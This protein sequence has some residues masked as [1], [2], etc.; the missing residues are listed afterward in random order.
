MLKVELHT[1]TEDDP[2]DKVPHSTRDLID[3]AISLGYD[4]LAITLHNRQ[5]DLQPWI[6]YAAARG[7]VLIPGVEATVAG[8]HVLLLNFERDAED[9]R[10]FEQLALLKQ[11]S[12]GLVIAPHPYF[13]APTSL[14]GYL[15][16]HAHLFDAVERNAMFTT[17]VDFNL[18]AERWAHAN[19]KPVVGNGDV[20]RLR[21]LG[22]T[23]TLV[24]AER[25]ADAICAAIAAG[26]V[27][28]VSEP[29]PWTTVVGVLCSLAAAGR[30]PGWR[31]T[32]RS[33]AESAHTHATDR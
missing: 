6:S 16:R 4:A 2:V 14:W 5:L 26:R 11:H 30:R 22:T 19:G 32:L 28:V 1:H 10:T 18:R 12:S 23:Y 33:N 8:K 31:R 7:L 27:R 24:D 29:L 21:Q 9:V 17:R 13:P 15:E 20:H 3:R 25:S